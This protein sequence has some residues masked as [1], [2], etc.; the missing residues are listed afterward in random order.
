MEFVEGWV[1]LL[2]LLILCPCQYVC[3]SVSFSNQ[4]P[5]N[6]ALGQ[7]LV[8]E[9]LVVQTPEEQVLSVMWEREEEGGSVQRK[10]RVA[11]FPGTPSNLRVTTKKEGAILSI[12]DFHKEDYGLYT[13]TITDRHGNQRFASRLVKQSE[14]A[15]KA[16]VSLLCDVPRGMEQWDSPEFLWLVDGEVVSNQT[17]N[18]SADGRKL[19][20]HTT[21]RQNY[22][23]IVSSSLGTSSVHYIIGL[24]C[25]EEQQTQNGCHAHIGVA[26][27]CSCLLILILLY[28]LYICRRCGLLQRLC[29]A[30][31]P[32]RNGAF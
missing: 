26:V 3:V 24:D 12:T 2:C 8:L 31:R 4:Q 11:E 6:V 9:A 10:V 27:F 25:A 32:E 21:C 13:I 17:A 7:R 30:K 5:L 14:K 28:I 1:S 19:F 23:C 16:S 18:L 29:P 20:I 15:P 22:T